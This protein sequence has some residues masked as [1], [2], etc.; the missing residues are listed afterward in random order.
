MSIFPYVHTHHHAVSDYEYS[1]VKDFA[2]LR[3]YISAEAA[4]ALGRVA[5][6]RCAV[7]EVKR[8]ELRL[9]EY[10]FEVCI[11]SKKDLLMLLHDEYI[12]GVQSQ[13]KS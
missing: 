2:V 4:N 8:V 1:Q 10:R 12:R 6:S 5:L 7:E 9:R 11:L 13:R 3:E